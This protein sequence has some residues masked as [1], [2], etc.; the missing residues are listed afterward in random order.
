MVSENLRDKGLI[1]L[2][3]IALAAT[4]LGVLSVLSRYLLATTFSFSDEI[5]T[6]LI[7]WGTLIAFGIG[8][9][10]NEHLRATV[11]LERLSPRWQTALGWVS[12]GATLLFAVLLVAYGV[13]IAWQRHLFNEVSPTVLRFP[14][15][16]ARAAVPAGFLIAI[17]ALLS[18]IKHK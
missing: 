1:L 8:E 12:F 4:V 2:G 6:Y 14:Q 5:V 15:W 18:R 7:V 9:F 17:V 13:E 11:L 3:A 16:I 10:S